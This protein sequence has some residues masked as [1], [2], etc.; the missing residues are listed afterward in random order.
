MKT[1]YLIVAY[2][3][4]HHF[5]R[6]V[7]ALADEQTHIFIHID[8]KV[9]QQDFEDALASGGKVPGYVEFIVAREKI[10]WGN[11]SLVEATLNLMRRAMN[12]VPDLDYA[13]FISGSDYPLASPQAI[14]DFLTEHKGT[15]FLDY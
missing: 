14:R 10:Y 5:S 15:E 9:R 11:F 13:C 7:R 4:P 8:G 6:L 2:N 3:I 12:V 1:A